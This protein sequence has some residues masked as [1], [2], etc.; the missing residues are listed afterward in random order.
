MACGRRAKRRDVFMKRIASKIGNA[1]RT[2]MTGRTVSDTGCS[3]KIMRADMARKMPPFK[4]M[5]RFLPNLMLWQGARVAEM[6]VNHRPRT[7]GVSKYGTIDR[8][9]S[10]GWDLLGVQW[11]RARFI[12][13][14]IKEKNRITSYNVCYTKLLRN[15]MSVR[16]SLQQTMREDVTMVCQGF[17]ADISED[18]ASKLRGLAYWGQSPLL[19]QAM[20]G[21]DTDAANAHLSGFMKA[22]DFIQNL[23]AYDMDGLATAST[24]PA[25]VGKAVITSYSIHYTKLYEDS[26]T[27]NS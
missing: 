15:Y 12:H 20:K 7:A 2:F 13:Y 14:E 27:R 26:G 11:L 25:A 3:L 16:Q 18:I 19:L 23:N 10:G 17:A 6:P 24:S 9:I 1:V 5:H 4:G 8:A 22:V 21:E